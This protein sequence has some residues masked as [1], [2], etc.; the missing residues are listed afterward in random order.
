MISFECINNN[1]SIFFTFK[2]YLTIIVSLHRCYILFKHDPT[3]MTSY[4]NRN[5]NQKPKGENNSTKINDLFLPIKRFSVT[6]SNK[7]EQMSIFS[8]S[9]MNNSSD[10]SNKRY[11]ADV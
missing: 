4:N 5:N 10:Q 1:Q 11:R 2:S 9:D 3:K 8:V 6:F 7:V